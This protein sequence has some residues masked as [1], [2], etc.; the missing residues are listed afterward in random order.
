[1]VTIAQPTKVKKSL[2]SY[3]FSARRYRLPL[4][5]VDS[6]S[7]SFHMLHVDLV[8]ESPIAPIL[9]SD[10]RILANGIPMRQPEW[11]MSWWEFY[12]S[13]DSELYLLTVRSRDRL[14]GLAPCY[15]NRSERQVR[16]LGDGEVC[17]DHNGILVSA[18]DPECGTSVIAALGDWLLDHCND[19]E[20][21]WESV[22]LE[23]ISGSDTRTRELQSL[24]ANRGCVAMER[25]PMN[26][27]CLDL[28]DGW[29][30]YLARASKDTRKRLRRRLSSLAD[31]QVHRVR[32][33]DDWN[34]YYAILIDLHQRRRNALGEPGC[35]ASPSFAQFL[36]KAS[37]RLLQLGQLQAFHLE[38]DGQPIAVEI[39]YRSSTQWYC[40]QGGIEPAV[41]E[42]EPGK[43]S[44]V[45]MM[46]QA[47][48]QGIHSIDFL[49]GDEPYKKQLKADPKSIT[50]LWVARPGW[51]GRSQ[52]WLWQSREILSEAARGLLQTLPVSSA[53][54]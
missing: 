32:S 54:S 22:Y 50:D 12:R 53:R 3:L 18:E 44:N 52:K 33:E 17:T 48:S 4:E 24:L 30:G 20:Y 49:R 27:W 43:M 47:Q 6:V 21:G 35:F 7:Q 13:N 5:I 1:M 39:G 51:K 31:V 34:R 19:R 14:V 11:L 41:M 15:R 28:R 45:W 9:W 36:E 38:K 2:P 23:G 16:L 29:E 46:S 10:W 25:N 37:L 42:I 8:S 40:Y 26:T